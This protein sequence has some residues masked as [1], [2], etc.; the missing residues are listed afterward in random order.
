MMTKTQF[1]IFAKEFYKEVG[2]PTTA[3]E[4]WDV[5]DLEYPEQDRELY[6]FLVPSNDSDFHLYRLQEAGYHI[7]SVKAEIDFWSLSKE[8]REEVEFYTKEY[9]SEEEYYDYD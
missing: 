4:A 9:C 1:K 6:R 5:R 8:E 3:I 2:I 7:L